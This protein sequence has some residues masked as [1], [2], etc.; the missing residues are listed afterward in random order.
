[1][2]AS[3]RRIRRPVQLSFAPVVKRVAPAVVNVYASRTIQ[4]DVSPF[5][6]DPFFRQFFGARSATSRTRASSARSAPASSSAP[7]A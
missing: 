3:S 7:M 2:I 6:S 4:E 5:F 1:M